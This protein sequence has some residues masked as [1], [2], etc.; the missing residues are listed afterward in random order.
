MNTNKMAYFAAF[1]P[2]PGEEVTCGE[3]QMWKKELE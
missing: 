1:C 3:K 2:D